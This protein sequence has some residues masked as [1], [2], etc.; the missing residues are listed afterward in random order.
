MLAS[1]KDRKVL[2]PLEITT[3]HLVCRRFLRIGRD[4][5]LWRD[6]SFEISRFAV[7]LRQRKRK[8]LLP[9]ISSSEPR[10]G[11]LHEGGTVDQ[12]RDRSVTSVARRDWHSS[13]QRTTE[14]IRVMANWDPSYEAEKIDWYT[15]FIQRTA[16]ISIRWSQKPL[17]QGVETESPLEV[18]GIGAH[19]LPGSGD[20][21]MTIAPLEDGSVCL[22]DAEGN[23]IGRSP[24]GSLRGTGRENAT[25]GITDGVSV[26]SDINRA[27]I[28][29][30]KGA[31]PDS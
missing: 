26:N 18:R 29:V 19:Y 10:F 24:E 4:N 25:C 13:N 7:N 3:T 1:N 14:R 6:E 27:F 5:N 16:P 31:C 12:L 11:D 21:G 17:K 20:V 28:A 9:T 22:W 15:E 30:E 8:E 2:T 23:I